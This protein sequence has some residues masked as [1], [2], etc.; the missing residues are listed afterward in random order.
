MALLDAG[1]VEL[2]VVF[3]LVGTQLDFLSALAGT[4]ATLLVIPLQVALVRYI[5]ALRLR[6]AERTD[7][8][9]MLTGEAIGGALAM[10]MLSWE[11]PLFG[12][13][14]ALRAQEARHVRGMA[15]IR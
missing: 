13:V 2:V 7:A 6:T 4:G 12:A 1:P 11:A 9:V 15:R 3:L 8:R 14:S 5:G 10:K